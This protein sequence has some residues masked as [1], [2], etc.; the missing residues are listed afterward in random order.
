VKTRIAFALV[1]LAAAS[2][3]AGDDPKAPAK[4]ADPGK[5][6]APAAKKERKAAP[7]AEATIRRYASLV[8]FPSAKYKCVEMNSHC[9]VQMMGGEVGCKFTIKDGGNVTMDIKL[10]DAVREQYGEAQL[11]NFKNGAKSL[12]QNVFKPFIVPADAMA[13][14]YDLAARVENGKPVVELT[15][16]AD[17]ATWDKLTLWFNA[18]GL[19]E[20]QKGTPNP[21]PNDPM[22]AMS[23]GDEIETTIAY[24]KHGDVWTIE[25][26]KITQAIGESTVKL[27]YYDIAGQSPLPKELTFATPMTPEPVVVGLT[28]YVLD[29]KPVPE[30][31]RKEEKKPDPAPAKKPDP[32]KPADPA[33]P[34]K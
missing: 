1:A 23:A 24:A 34:A 11:A 19:L 9:D 7:E 18:D 3:S 13:K 6:A 14:Q 28:D 22:A 26:A 25:G 2:A 15:R 10:P 33:K 20:R 30:T 4:P 21:D 29:G 8:A 16:F 31:A 32:G 17:D 12:I 27:A 5:S